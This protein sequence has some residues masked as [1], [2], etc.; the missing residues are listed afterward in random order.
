VQIPSF[1]VKNKDFGSEYAV[2]LSK[3]R[4]IFIAGV[5]YRS[6]ICGIGKVSF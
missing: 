1:F 2:I 6:M 4:D 3:T 5:K